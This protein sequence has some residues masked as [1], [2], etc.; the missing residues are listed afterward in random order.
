MKREYIRTEEMKQLLILVPDLRN[1]KLSLDSELKRLQEF[2]KDMDSD[3]IE[4]ATFGGFELSD[5][6]FAKTNKTSD[7]TADI[8]ISHQNNIEAKE[9]EKAKKEVVREK[10]YIEAVLDKIEIGLRAV[11]KVQSKV[12]ELKYYRDYPWNEIL[13]EI[14]SDKFFYSRA[15]I[16][17][18]VKRTIIK[19]T[20]ITMID[21]QMYKNVMSLVEKTNN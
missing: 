3:Y 4:S 13:T 8:A 2:E 19:L 20:T 12:V 7:R 14:E 15:K 16:Q 17:R 18:M 1:M 11:G 21:V 5:M 9:I 10:Y 6:P